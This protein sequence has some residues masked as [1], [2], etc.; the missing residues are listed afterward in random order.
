MYLAREDFIGFGLLIVH[1]RML[2]V[3][4]SHCSA[5]NI[6]FHYKKKNI[7]NWQGI[8]MSLSIYGTVFII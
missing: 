4:F 1:D 2:L 3:D 5:K 6:L 7:K 8:A